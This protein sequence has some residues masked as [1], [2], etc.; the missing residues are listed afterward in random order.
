ML[1]AEVGG[2]PADLW[3]VE[4]SSYL[5]SWGRS[6][7]PIY[8]FNTQAA[9]QWGQH[10][11]KQSEPST[12][13]NQNKWWNV[14]SQRQQGS[15]HPWS[16]GMAREAENGCGKQIEPSI[17]IPDVTPTKLHV[18]WT[19]SIGSVGHEDGD[20]KRCAFFPKGRCK[21]GENCT[22]CHLEHPKQ[23]RHRRRQQR[24]VRRAWDVAPSEGVG[25]EAEVHRRGP[26]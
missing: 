26:G 12:W 2:A 3:D 4:W 17:N 13:H 7:V 21:N 10:F 9:V 23:V 24:N 19:R 1:H 25:A 22:H 5:P 20:C 14:P 8:K 18:A 11:A 15:K 6:A 16:L